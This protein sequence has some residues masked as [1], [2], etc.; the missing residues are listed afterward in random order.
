MCDGRLLTV[1]YDVYFQRFQDGDAVPG[2]GDRARAVLEPHFTE[3][4]AHHNFARVTLGDDGA[5]VYLD[6]NDMMVNHAG[7]DRVWDLLIKAARAADWVILLP[8]GPP[9]LTS[10]TQRGELPR[11]LATDAV[12]VSNGADYLEVLR[13]I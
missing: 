13:Q 2:G 9:C 4:D 12:L 10:P 5:D 7:G 1:S 8:D 6:D 3:T 11:E